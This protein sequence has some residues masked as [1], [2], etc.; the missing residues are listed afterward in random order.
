MSNV[1]SWEMKKRQ[2]G[3]TQILFAN[4][5]ALTRRLFLKGFYMFYYLLMLFKV[6]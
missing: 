4:N 2:M 5:R 6:I 3:F 1:E